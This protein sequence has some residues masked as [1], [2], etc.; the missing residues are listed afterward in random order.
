MRRTTQGAA[1]VGEAQVAGTEAAKAAKEGQGLAGVGAA[2]AAVAGG[3]GV[4]RS[5]VWRT[6]RHM[7]ARGAARAFAGR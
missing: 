3:A 6:G 5:E 1:A 2:G 7:C 4:A